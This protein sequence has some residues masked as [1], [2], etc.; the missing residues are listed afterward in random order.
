MIQNNFGQD[1]EFLKKYVETI[2]LTNGQGGQ[3]AVVPDYQ[4][5]T[6]TCTANKDLGNSYGWI[7]YDLIAS[8]QRDPVVNLYGGEDRFWIS[9]EGGQ[10]SLFFDPGDPMDLAHWRTP[11]LI[12]TEPFDVVAQ[13]ESS[14]A[15]QKRGQMTNYSR[16][17][18]D[19]QF[20]RKVIVPDPASAAAR[21]SIN[22][23]GLRAVAH[24]SHNRLTNVGDQDWKPETGLIG[25]WVLCMNA[26]SPRATVVI[27]YQTG[28]DAERGPIVNAD[29]FGKLGADRLQVDDSRGLIY[30]LGDGLFRSKLGLQLGRVKPT[31]GSWDPLRQA[32]S[33]VDFN[34]PDE[35]PTG[36]TNNLWEIQDN[37]FAGDVINSYNDGPNETGGM[38]GPFFELETISPALALK[39]GE[40]YTHLHRTLRLEGDPDALNRA[41][42]TVFGISLEEIE[43]KFGESAGNHE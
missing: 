41:A 42:E 34:L 7:N 19:M 22:L 29:Y 28:S 11:A 37:P 30:F 31:M 17:T 13:D 35:A 26:P 9:P 16:F 32:L 8:G 23:D 40:G 6:M 39:P 15:F 20:D 10:F 12:D 36:Y 2:V 25:I 1:V 4:G 38:L 33:I 14:V 27:P 5:R 43:T 24:E 18:F 3:V 21:F